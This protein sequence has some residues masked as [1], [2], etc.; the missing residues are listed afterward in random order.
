MIIRRARIGDEKGIAKVHVDSWKSTYKNIVPEEYLN[1]LSYEQREVMWKRGIADNNPIF[2][3]EDFGSIVGFATGGKERSAKYE[4][5]EGEVYAIYILKEYEGRGIG[6]RL[7]N[8]V[9]NEIVGYG[10][11]SMI[12]LVLEDN[13][14]IQFYE[15]L[16]GTKLD[17][18]EI[19]IGGKKLKEA[20][21]G[22]TTIEADMF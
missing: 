19:E 10:M 8:Q 18:V 17:I 7:F 2:V 6:K 15:A 5:Y 3:A 16:G 11:N 1:T 20:I 22:W 13:P 12:V 9:V 21:Y 4:E 14:S